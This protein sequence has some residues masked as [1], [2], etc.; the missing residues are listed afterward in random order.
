MILED[1]CN[2]ITHHCPEL[3]YWLP[4]GKYSRKTPKLCRSGQLLAYYHFCGVCLFFWLVKQHPAIE[5]KP[6]VWQQ[7]LTET[8]IPGSSLG[9]V[10]PYYPHM[11]EYLPTCTHYREMGHVHFHSIYNH[12]FSSPALSQLILWFPTALKSIKASC[13]G[14]GCDVLPQCA[15][16][17]VHIKSSLCWSG[18]TIPPCSCGHSTAGLWK[19]SELQPVFLSIIF[20]S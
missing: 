9:Q 5:I 19:L 13:H 20:P 11:Y 4:K 6:Q 18:I 10:L 16:L 17:W 7:V 14:N 2:L 8:N 15:H 3:F 12:S 1:F